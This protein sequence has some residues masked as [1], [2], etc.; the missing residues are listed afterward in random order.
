M[1][2]MEWEVTSRL[3]Q[4]GRAWTYSCQVGGMAGGLGEGSWWMRE[5]SWKCREVRLVAASMG[6]ASGG[7]SLTVREGALW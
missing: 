2:G 6:T 1:S 7:S 3:S 5:T 4:W